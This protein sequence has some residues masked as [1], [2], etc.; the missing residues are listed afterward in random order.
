[1]TWLDKVELEALEKLKKFNIVV[2]RDKDYDYMTVDNAWGVCFY[3]KSTKL[4]CYNLLSDEFYD[5][6]KVANEDGSY[7]QANG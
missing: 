2:K 5:Y 3:N 7:K 6:R 1:M 4:F